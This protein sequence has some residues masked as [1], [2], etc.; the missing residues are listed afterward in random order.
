[1]AD[2]TGKTLGRVQ[3]NDLIARGG[4]AE[5]YTGIHETHGLVAVKI[6]RGLLEREEHQL[7]RFKREAEVIGEMRHPNIVRML[8]F[9]IVDETPCLIMDFIPG[10]SLAVYL[11]ELHARNQLN[12]NCHNRPNPD[13]PCERAGLR[14]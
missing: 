7:T 11:K 9:T 10:P 13:V 3:I 5:I 14:P 1:M 2:W 6:M 4:M 8:D 12:S